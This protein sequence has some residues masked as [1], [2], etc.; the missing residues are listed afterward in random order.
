MI[1]PKPA[2]R[3]RDKELLRELHSRWRECC[4]CGETDRLSLHHVIKHPRDDVEGNLVMLCG[5]GVRGCHGLIEAH[6]GP[7]KKHLANYLLAER[8]DVVLHIRMTLGLDAAAVWFQR[9]LS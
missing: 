6:H 7:T 1:D 5:D 4:L 9:H 3:I 8:A 2:K